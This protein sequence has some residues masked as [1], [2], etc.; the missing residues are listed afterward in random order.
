MAMIRI[1]LTG[2]HGKHQSLAKKK[3]TIKKDT[4]FAYP[5]LTLHFVCACVFMMQKPSP[6][7]S[8]PNNE[9]TVLLVI[10]L[11]AQ[12]DTFAFYAFASNGIALCHDTLSI[13]YS[14]S[15][16]LYRHTFSQHHN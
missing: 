11:A 12:S 5:K 6:N 13:S 2:Y 8:Q 7:H 10:L 4:S 3:S 14:N 9:V 1:A 15:N 16:S